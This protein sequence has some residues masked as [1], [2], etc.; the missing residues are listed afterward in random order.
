MIEYFKKRKDRIIGF[1]NAVRNRLENSNTN[2]ESKEIPD[3]LLEICPECN[4][5]VL[6]EDIKNRDYTCPNCGFHHKISARS[7]IEM[8]LDK[9][10]FKEMF[11]GF[12]TTNPLGITGYSE[13]ISKL[14]DA[15]FDEAIVTGI[16]KIDNYDVAIG[17]MESEFLM[18]SMGVVVGEKIA[19][20][21]EFAT[22]SNLPL[23]IFTTSGGARM[24]EGILSLM[25]MAKTTAAIGRHNAAGLLYISV[26]C[27]P[28]FGGVSASFATIADVI[29][30]EPKALIGFAGP[31]VIKETIKQELPDGFQSAEFLLETGQVDKIV[32]RPEI[33]KTLATLIKLHKVQVE[34]RGTA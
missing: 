25:Q 13:K 15:G 12:K 6:F 28:T 2:L 23:V 30:A 19:L 34:N 29:L 20:L 3:N 16:G 11:D 5:K 31:R 7:R 27:S 24:Q 17:V 10:S 21:A 4:T 18:G 26:L 33:S 32:P 14:K 8:L 22:K 9:N 1:Q